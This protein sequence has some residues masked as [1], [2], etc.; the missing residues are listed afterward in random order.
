M[1]K[2]LGHLLV[3]VQTVS[4]VLTQGALNF[5]LEDR[6]RGESLIL[7]KLLSSTYNCPLQSRFNMPNSQKL[8]AN[9]S[10]VSSSAK[11]NPQPRSSMATRPKPAS[12]PL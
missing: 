6:F 8:A 1:R 2:L 5:P 4:I 11:E 12:E 7:I 9:T 3:F 10:K